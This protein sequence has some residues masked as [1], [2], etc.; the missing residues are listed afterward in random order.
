[1]P[2]RAQQHPPLLFFLED[3][4]FEDEAFL[5]D[6]FSV[7]AAVAEASGAAVVAADGSAVTADVTC[8]AGSV[9]GRVAVAAAGSGTGTM[10]GSCEGYAIMDGTVCRV[11]VG[12][13]GAAL[14]TVGAD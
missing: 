8:A 1:M 5:D 9:A 10:V 12:A 13:A 4:F 7:L 6:L 14:T 3:S 2:W 11:A